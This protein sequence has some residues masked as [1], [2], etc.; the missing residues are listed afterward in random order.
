[1]AMTAK[2]P[3]TCGRCQQ[4][5]N[6]GDPIG[7]SDRVVGWLHEQ[8]AEMSEDDSQEIAPSDFADRYRSD[9]SQT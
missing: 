4:P 8:C 7:K 6:V 1:M 2:Y 5:I 9:P 3:G